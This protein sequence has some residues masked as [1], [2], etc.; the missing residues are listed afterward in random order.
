MASSSDP[1]ATPSVRF[2]R[3]AIVVMGVSGAG[4]TTVGRL[5]AGR[6][7]VE[8]IDGDDLHSPA[9]RAKMAAGQAL[10]DADRWPWLDRIA[11]ALADPAAPRGRVIACSALKRAYRDRLRAGAGAGLR[12]VYLEANPDLMRKRVAGRR[13]HYMP[14]SLVDSQFAALE[15][16]ARE[17]DVVTIAADADLD[18]AIPQLVAELARS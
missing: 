1:T 13:G 2:G 12:F 7:G 9:T 3:V 4:K 5:L 15:P 18:V 17:A 6:L 8:F 10:D 14:A 16:P 11:A